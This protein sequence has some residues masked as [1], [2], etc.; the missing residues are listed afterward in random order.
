MWKGQRE[1]GSR[2]AMGRKRVGREMARIRRCGRLGNSNG[3][4]IGL[5]G[6]A[7]AVDGGSGE[8]DGGRE[9]GDSAA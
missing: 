9:S 2:G 8:G 3:E 4:G 6:A 1:G 5:V 7:A